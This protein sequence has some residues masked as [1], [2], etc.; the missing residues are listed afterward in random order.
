MIEASDADPVGP[1]HMDSTDPD[2]D[3]PHGHVSCLPSLFLIAHIMCV[4]VG[5]TTFGVLFWIRF[6]KPAFVRN[7]VLVIEWIRYHL[8]LSWQVGSP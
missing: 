4:V 6:M 1:K 2:L 8:L 3:L 5:S 7:R